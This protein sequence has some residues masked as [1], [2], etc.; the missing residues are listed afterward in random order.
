MLDFVLNSLEQ[1]NRLIWR[2]KA[3]N[4]AE[5]SSLALA[6]EEVTFSYHTMLKYLLQTNW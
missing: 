4:V 6:K 2:F 3:E 1:G 5:E